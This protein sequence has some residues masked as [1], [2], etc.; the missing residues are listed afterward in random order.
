[1][2]YKTQSA[3]LDNLKIIVFVKRNL[4]KKLSN[5]F[6]HDILYFLLLEIK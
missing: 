3:N 5:F 4:I 6:L 2:V 1:M